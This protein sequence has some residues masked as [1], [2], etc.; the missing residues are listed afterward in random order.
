MKTPSSIRAAMTRVTITETRAR[1]MGNIFERDEFQIK[2]IWLNRTQTPL[3]SFHG[4]SHHAIFNDKTKEPLI[5]NFENGMSPLMLD[6][7]ID[8]MSIQIQ[9]KCMHWQGDEDLILMRDHAY[10]IFGCCAA[11]NR[12]WSLGCWA[13]TSRYTLHW[14]NFLYF[15]GAWLSGVSPAW[16]A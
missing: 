3:Q 4:N 9:I 8:E 1:V 16:L 11:R 5:H 12:R 10:A 6:R 2:S 14:H 15:S 13:S 7:N